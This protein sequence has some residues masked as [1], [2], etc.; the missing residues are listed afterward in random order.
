MD[1]LHADTLEPSVSQLETTQC[2][3]PQYAEVWNDLMHDCDVGSPKDVAKSCNRHGPL[4]M[5]D[6]KVR[7][8]NSAPFC[9]LLTISAL[10]ESGNFLLDQ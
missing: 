2:I 4:N 9:Y 7:V 1:F 6:S 5:K 8:L 10:L 3:D